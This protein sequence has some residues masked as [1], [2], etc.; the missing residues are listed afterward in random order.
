MKS[1]LS[2]VLIPQH[3]L[4]DYDKALRHLE[5]VK[6]TAT[7]ISHAYADFDPAELDLSEIDCQPQLEESLKLIQ[8]YFQ[9]AI[10]Q[11]KMVDRKVLVPLPDHDGLSKTKAIIRLMR[12]R[13]R[14][15]TDSRVVRAFRIWQK[16]LLYPYIDECQQV[17]FLSKKSIF[18]KR[19]C[20]IARVA[21]IRVRLAFE[22]W[23]CYAR[24]FST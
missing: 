24:K 12:L 9:E 13:K 16:A 23:I 14:D 5:I 1:N 2:A 11:S 7:Q 4:V 8:A 17:M 18:K 10:R 19:L 3:G 22:K 20:F 15:H 6:K 21:R